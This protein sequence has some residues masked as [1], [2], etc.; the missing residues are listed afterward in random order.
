MRVGTEITID[1]LGR[2]VIPKGYRDFYHI[3]K[4]DK[5]S[6]ICTPDGLLITNPKYK[7]VEITQDNNKGTNT[8]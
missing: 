7:V 8:L 2:I 3:N 4:E 6:L 1:K 5:L